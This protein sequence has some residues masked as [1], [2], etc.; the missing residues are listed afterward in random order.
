MKKLSYIILALAALVMSAC[1]DKDYEITPMKLSPIEKSQIS[2]NLVGDD[3][4]ISWPAL[5]NGCKMQVTRYI[6]TSVNASEVVE[7]TQYKHAFV[8]T[9]VNFTYVL[10][11]TDGANLSYGTA[12]EYRRPGAS[13]ITGIS[14]SQVETASGYDANVTWN[15]ASGITSIKFVATNGTKNINE[16]LAG[17]ATSYVIPDVKNGET[18][19][20]TLTAVN[21]EGPS[22]PASSSLKIGNT[23]IGFLSI[24]D[25]PEEHIANSDD[26]EASAWLWLTS[27][28]PTAK[29]VSFK[30]IKSAADLEKFR[31][32][33]WL[34]DLENVGEDEVLNM[35]E[36]V[37]SVTPAIQEWYKNG[38]SLLLWS[39]AMPYIET[40]GRIPA[41]T[42]KG[43]DRAIG[44]GAGGWNP[45]TWKMAVCLN[46]GSKF[47]KDASSHPLFR[48]LETES[49]DRTVLIAM[50]GAGWTE[51]HNCLFFNYPSALTGLG[52]QEEECYNQLVNKFGIIPL[53]TW[54]SQIDWVSQ[55]NVW[56]AQQGNTEFKGTILCVGNG[57]CEFSMKNADGTPDKSALPKNNPYQSNVLKLATN[58]LEYL[59]TR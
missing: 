45:D 39:H 57:G 17:S 51:D 20:V 48:G 50:K 36:V 6:G 4:V 12:I 35:P 29:F 42:I 3:Y 23:T 49:T 46:P 34:R 38:G 58:A 47:R 7:G 37:K 21:A 15:A 52:N 10:K 11:V 56:E 25:T 2:G 16:D 24:Y 40:L 13:S 1:Q 43:N 30:D 26:D 28:Y 31:V 32:L 27:A 44:T 19:T 5:P 59:K 54:D 41:G 8:E 14:M 18:W 33:F 9:N 55:L 22:L 53:A